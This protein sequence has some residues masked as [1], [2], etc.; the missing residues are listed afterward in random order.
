MLETN[1]RYLAEKTNLE[2]QL[3]AKTEEL[4]E[5]TERLKALQLQKDQE[6]AAMREK[7]EKL[8]RQSQESADALEKR[9]DS[10]VLHWQQ[11]SHDFEQKCNELRGELA[12]AQQAARDAAE[13]VRANSVEPAMSGTVRPWDFAQESEWAQGAK[14]SKNH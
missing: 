4:T 14:W 2:A 5:L 9:K 10:Q 8:L 11:Q 3:Q 6:L 1:E 13:Q 7:C 12:R